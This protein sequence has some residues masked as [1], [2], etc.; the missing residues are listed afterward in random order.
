[1]FWNKK[2]VRLELVEYMH[3]FLNRETVVSGTWRFLTQTD[4]TILDNKLNLIL[5]H[6]NLEYVPETEKKEPAKLVEKKLLTGMDLVS[7][8][9]VDATCFPV[10]YSGS[11]KIPTHQEV[12]N[13]ISKAS[14]KRTYKKTGK[15]SKKK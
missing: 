1:M 8:D 2:N 4:Y 3:P 10:L 15:Y 5:N 14:T 9:R 11:N 6:L 12:T 13:V 7:G